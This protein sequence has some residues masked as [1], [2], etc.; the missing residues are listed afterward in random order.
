[1]D[2]LA[3]AIDSLKVEFEDQETADAIGAI[4]LREI[5]LNL[6][7]NINLAPIITLYITFNKIANPELTFTTEMQEQLFLTLNHLNEA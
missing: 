5:N 7:T 3:K 4:N 6:H 2:I 1:M